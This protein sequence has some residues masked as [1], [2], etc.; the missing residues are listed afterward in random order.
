MNNHF[1][2]LLKQGDD[3]LELIFKKLGCSY[4]YYFNQ[5]YDL[6]GHLFQ[7]RFNS[8]IVENDEYFLSVLRY[9]FQNPV[10][11]GLCDA[12]ENYKWLGC[13]G[14]TNDKRLLDPINDYTDLYGDQL[15]S[16]VNSPCTLSHIDET[17]K[18]RI[19]DNEAIARIRDRCGCIH[20]QEISG[21]ESERLQNAI[22]AGVKTGISIRQLSRITGINRKKIACIIN[23]QK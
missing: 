17:D 20:V 14:I 23:N 1:H 9:I 22:I 5:K 3:P 15:K 4:V 8:E 7:D 21:W 2:L 11:A 13:S 18:K 16:F 12:P 6:H 10:K 19:T